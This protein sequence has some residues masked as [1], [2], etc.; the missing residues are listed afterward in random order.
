LQRK[1]QKV[2]EEAPAANLP[3]AIRNGL[4]ESALKLIRHTRY[5]SAGTIEF[6]VESGADGIPQEFFFIEMNTRLQVEHPVTEAIT[7]IDLVHE[8]IKL[9]LSAGRYEFPVVTEPRGHAIEVRICAEDPSREF[10]PCTGKIDQLMLPSGPGIRVDR[11]IEV[12]QE[13]GTQFDSMCGKIITHAPTR[14]LAVKRIQYALKETVIGGVGTNLDYLNAIAHSDAVI[15]GRMSTHYLDR[16][17]KTY[18]PD[19]T[20]PILAMIEAFEKSPEFSNQVRHESGSA[21]HPGK[22]SSTSLWSQNQL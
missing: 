11:G 14:D 6:L 13:L 9:A 2:W 1:H 22:A 5:R 8:Q 21:N 3:D 17:F 19:V 16:D 15:T 7:G 18:S 10:I 20:A 4:Y 12:G